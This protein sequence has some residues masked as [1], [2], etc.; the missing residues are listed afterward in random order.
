MAFVFSRLFLWAVAWMSYH[1]FRH[2]EFGI[3]KGDVLWNLLLRWDANWYSSII[4]SGYSYV[5]GKESNVAFFP[6]YPLCVRAFR[7]LTHAPVPLAGFLL[8]NTFLLG[9]VVLLHR[10]VRLDFPEPSPVPART[11]WLLLFNPVAFFHA[12]LYTESLFL[13][14]SLGAF[15]A[16]RQRRWALAGLA[17]G[18]LATTRTNG[19][20]IGLPLFWEAV[21]EPWRRGELRLG[22]A[23]RACLWLTLVPLGLAAY[24][25]Y[26]YFNFGDALAFA[27][28]QSAG[29]NRTLSWPWRTVLDARYYPGVYQ[30]LFYGSGAIAL[31]A[32]IVGF[33]I[34]V[35]MSYLLYAVVTILLLLCSSMLEGLPRYLSVLFPLPLVLAAV[36]AKSENAYLAILGTNAAFFT[37]CLALYVGGYWMT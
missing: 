13:F 36:T 8:S 16:A 4:E 14:L 15:F 18:L 33:C 25:A 22:P 24:C 23:T 1:A 29:W 21:V 12:A 28:A 32:L 17:G 26:L 27:H 10:L 20:L 19:I 6:L 31:I 11:V 5:A 34:R 30:R 3:A 37:L 2:G 9:A 7:W 35:R